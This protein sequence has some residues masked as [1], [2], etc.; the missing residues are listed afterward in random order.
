MANINSVISYES[1][2]LA[3]NL[4][5]DIMRIGIENKGIFNNTNAGS[6]YCFTGKTVKKDFTYYVRNSDGKTTEKTEEYEIPVTIAING[7]SNLNSNSTYGIKFQVD[8]NGYITG[9]SLVEI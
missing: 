1:G 5:L 9:G 6:I 8:S 4:P 3:D 7:P 2:C